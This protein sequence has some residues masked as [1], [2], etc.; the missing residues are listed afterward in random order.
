[1]MEFNELEFLKWFY[2]ICDFG[3]A[4]EDVIRMYLDAYEEETGQDVPEEY[5]WWKEDEDEE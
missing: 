4:H 3:P 2:N 1:M 5:A